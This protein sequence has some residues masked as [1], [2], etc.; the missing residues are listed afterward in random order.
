MND[1]N[2]SIHSHCLG[3]DL[4][5]RQCRV[6]Q[7][8]MYSPNPHECKRAKQWN[9]RNSCARESHKLNEIVYAH[10]QTAFVKLVFA[11][12][13]RRTHQIA[14]WET[15]TF[16][17]RQS[18]TK[19]AFCFP[20]RCSFFFL[21]IFGFGLNSVAIWFVRTQLTMTLVDFQASIPLC[22]RL[23][24]A[25]PHSHLSREQAKNVNTFFYD[26]CENSGLHIHRC[27][28][29]LSLSLSL[30]RV[31]ISRIDRE[32]K[33]QDHKRFALVLNAICCHWM[34][35]FACLFTP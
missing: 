5:W 8:E 2:W 16:L 30:P 7:T 15:I 21:H 25:R 3:M 24:R 10:N 1:L 6:T 9:G 22:F 14:Q 13:P 31:S 35:F 20:F 33:P 17:F 4:R 18:T 32:Q 11:H 34:C 19:I 23:F 29:F 26:D 27:F 28:S 12:L